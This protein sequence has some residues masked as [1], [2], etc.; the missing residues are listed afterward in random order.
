MTLETSPDIHDEDA[1]Y[2]A[3]RELQDLVIQLLDNN[4]IDYL[5]QIIETFHVA[6]IADLI[7]SLRADDRYR[8]LQA[9]KAYISPE[10][11]SKLDPSVMDDVFKVLGS[12]A[13]AAAVTGLETDDAL[14]IIE[15]MDPLQQQEILNA[16]PADERAILQEVLTIRFS[17]FVSCF[18]DRT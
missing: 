18:G 11:L 7:R 2:G 15:E 3:S 13:I 16:I 8:F 6:D 9:A 10:L 17:L 1:L 4:N 12:R 5:H 14:E